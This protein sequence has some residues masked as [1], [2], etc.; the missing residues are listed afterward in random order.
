MNA[1]LQMN[2][3]KKIRDWAGIWTQDLLPRLLSQILS[4]SQFGI[5]LRSLGS[6]SVACLLLLWQGS[7][8]FNGKSVSLVFRIEILGS[9]P[10]WISDFYPLMK[11]SSNKYLR[12]QLNT[13][14]SDSVNVCMCGRLVHTDRV[15]SFSVSCAIIYTTCRQNNI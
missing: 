10:S 9:N 7:K 2:P 15:Q 1:F 3:Q 12:S 14:I 8:W 5:R 4:L 11:T 13:F 6:A